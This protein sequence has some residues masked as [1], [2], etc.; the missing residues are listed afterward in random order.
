MYVGE[1]Q[2]KHITTYLAKSEANAPSRTRPPLFGLLPAPWYIWQ[3]RVYWLAFL[4][5]GHAGFYSSDTHKH[6]SPHRKTVVVVVV[7]VGIVCMHCWEKKKRK[8]PHSA[9]CLHSVIDSAQRRGGGWGCC[10]AS[11]PIAKETRS[12]DVTLSPLMMVMSS[13][14]TRGRG[15]DCCTLMTLLHEI[16]MLGWTG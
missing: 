11:H 1:D 2:L 6:I 8:G 9:S 16:F 13:K 14:K 10:W 15:G 7:V 4:M 12:H 5:P 3:P